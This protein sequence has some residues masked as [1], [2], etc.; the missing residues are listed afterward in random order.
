MFW[1]LHLGGAHFSSS[2]ELQ[3]GSARCSFLGSRESR[4]GILAFNLRQMTN[5][6]CFSIFSS[7]KMGII[8]LPHL[9][10]LLW[11]WGEC[12]R[13]RP[14]ETLLQILKQHSVS[15]PV[16]P[17]GIGSSSCTVTNGPPVGLRLIPMGLLLLNVL[18]WENRENF[19]GHSADK[20]QWLWAQLHFSW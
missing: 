4:K 7:I 19:L 5:P 2:P 11:G 16:C 9:W 1:Q 15:T 12:Y 14:T 6:L 13:H 18:F 17:A 10:A 8:I 20:Q 3:Y